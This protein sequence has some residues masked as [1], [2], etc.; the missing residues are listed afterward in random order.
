MLRV[1]RKKCA[2][3]L[4]QRVIHAQGLLDLDKGMKTGPYLWHDEVMLELTLR[5][6]E[7]IRLQIRQ[8]NSG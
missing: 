8:G 4:A 6:G 7:S 1:Q 5:P 2:T 3:F